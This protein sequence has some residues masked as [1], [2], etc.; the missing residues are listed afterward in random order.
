MQFY[1]TSDVINWRSQ[2]R[3]Q[4]ICSRN[5]DVTMERTTSE[6]RSYKRMPKYAICQLSRERKDSIDM[7]T[8]GKQRQ[9]LNE[10]EEGGSLDRNEST[11][12]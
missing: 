4:I 10:R 12:P 3:E 9:H 5:E 6:I 11:T 8:S 1:R 2:R 7:E